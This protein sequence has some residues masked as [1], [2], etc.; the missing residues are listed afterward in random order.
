MS[1]CV[2]L[3]NGRVFYT[4]RTQH[5]A[6]TSI[7]T[8]T[9]VHVKQDRERKLFIQFFITVVV[10]VVYDLMFNVLPVVSKRYGGFV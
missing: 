4:I 10:F 8:P 9:H 3:L 6:T 2:L 7:D 5:A 1:V